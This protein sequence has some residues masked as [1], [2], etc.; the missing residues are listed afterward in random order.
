MRE[1]NIAPHIYPQPT[2]AKHYWHTPSQITGHALRTIAPSERVF[3]H[4][5]KTSHAREEKGGWE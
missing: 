4:I 1:R 3:L 2:L 5:D